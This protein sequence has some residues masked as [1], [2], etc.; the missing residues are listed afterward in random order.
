MSQIWFILI[1]LLCTAYES[2]KNNKFHPISVLISTGPKIIK[3]RLKTRLKSQA[4]DWL[5]SCFIHVLEMQMCAKEYTNVNLNINL[6]S[7]IPKILF[8]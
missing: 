8:S 2:L 1:E 7:C 4:S 3:L 5:N 6:C